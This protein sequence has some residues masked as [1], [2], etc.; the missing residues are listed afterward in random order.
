MLLPI[1]DIQRFCIHDGPGI[2]T[3]VFFKGCPLRCKWCHN[4]ETQNSNQEILFHE[5]KCISC[6]SCI[7]ICKQNAHKIIDNVHVFDRDLCIACGE[8]IDLCIGA[9]TPA[10]KTI[11]LTDLISV[12]EKDRPFYKESGGV[13]LSGGEP[14]MHSSEATL[15]LKECKKRGISTAI[16]TCGYFNSDILEDVV[17][18]TDL[19]L[20][21][22]KATDDFQHKLYTGKS[23]RLIIDN[24]QK[25]DKLGARTRL[26]CILVN[27]VN[28]LESHYQ[29]IAEI[30]LSLSNC[31]GVEFIPYH[32]YGCSK[33]LLLGQSENGH[34]DWIP[35]SETV[36]KAC[37]YIKK[38]NVTVI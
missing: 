14:L 31:E 11:R 7:R 20:W 30:A 34:K 28:T 37:N 25:A 3:T 12:I 19:F 17:K 36:E 10:K 29:K 23:N 24:L 16:E 38:H 13:T 32:P 5:K 18:H 35:S 27:N 9:I 4:P 22:I 8:C 21:D 1:T 15:L 2:R 33:M 6:G 26:R